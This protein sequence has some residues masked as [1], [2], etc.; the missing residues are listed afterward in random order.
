[1]PQPIN[2]EVSLEVID[3]I[4]P[5]SLTSVDRLLLLSVVNDAWNLDIIVKL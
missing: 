2:N 5:S 1:M 4:A 3:L